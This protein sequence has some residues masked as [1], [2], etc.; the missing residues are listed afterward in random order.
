[1]LE[2]LELQNVGPAPRMRFDFAPRLN[3]LTG[4]N[5][6]GKSFVL[7]LA[8]WGLTRTWAGPEAQPTRHGP[9]VHAA[10]SYRTREVDRERSQQWDFDRSQWRW[11]LKHEPDLPPD[12][13]AEFRQASERA[14]GS[15]VLALYA[16]PDGGFSAWDPMR[17][18]QPVALGGGSFLN[19]PLPSD[20]TADEVFNGLV[21]QTVKGTYVVSNGLIRDWTTWQDRRQEVFEVFARVLE[22]LSPHPDKERIRPGAPLRISPGDARDIPTLVLPYGEIPITLV[23]AGI[24]RI[25]SLAYL[26]VWLWHEHQEAIKLK[27]LAPSR[28]LIV[29]IDEIETHLHPQWQRVI[30]PALFKVIPDLEKALNVQVVA[31]THAPLVLASVEP[32]FDESQDALFLFDVTGEEVKVG[33]SAWRPRGNASAW[34]TSEVFGLKQDRSL[35]AERAIQSALEALRQPDLPIEEVR[36]IH[37]SLQGVL[38]DTDPF[39][40]RWL[41]RAERAGIEP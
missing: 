26:L 33:R 16:R 20:F 31:T 13:P 7:D 9:N 3:L 19:R 39:W 10:V 1:M 4:D 36:R 11:K 37:R 27:G 8:W 15:Y 12:T 22:G 38:K 35:E 21:G 41:A 2:V 30:L 28:E 18:V 17:D 6:L 23:S 14:P 34:L 32:L 40:P 5:G 24:K 25:L 29:L